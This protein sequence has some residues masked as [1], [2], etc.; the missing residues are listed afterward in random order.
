MVILVVLQ[1]ILQI[2]SSILRFYALKIFLCFWYLTCTYSNVLL[3]KL[4]VRSNMQLL[5][6]ENQAQYNRAK[7][8]NNPY[9]STVSL[10][11]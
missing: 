5:Q 7:Q 10:P 2:E 9:E 6:K 3:V 8:H 4:V 11:T 1:L